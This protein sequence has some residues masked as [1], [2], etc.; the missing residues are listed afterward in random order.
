MQLHTTKY[1]FKF[2]FD[3]NQYFTKINVLYGPNLSQV[4]MVLGLLCSKDTSAS[5]SYLASEQKLIMLL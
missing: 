3:L 5:F 1:S 2:R 4:K